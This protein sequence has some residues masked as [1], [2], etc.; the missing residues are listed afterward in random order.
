[1]EVPSSGIINR[2]IAC[3]GPLSGTCSDFW[4][5]IWEQ[6]STLVVMLTTVVEQGRFVFKSYLCNLYY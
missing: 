3:Q 5:M 2:Y 4:Q 6:Q 1:M